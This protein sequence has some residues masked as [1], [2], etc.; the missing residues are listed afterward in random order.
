MDQPIVEHDVATWDQLAGAGCPVN[1]LAADI[2]AKVTVGMLLEAACW[3]SPGLVSPVDSGGHTDMTLPTF[4]SSSSVLAPGF[5]ILAALGGAGADQVPG[6]VMPQL[7]ATGKLFEQRMLQATGGV[8]THRG[9]LFLGGLLAAAAG[10]LSA[11]KG[12][13]S[14]RAGD[15]TAAAIGSTVA[16]FTSGIVRDELAQGYGSDR[17]LRLYQSS[18]LTGPRGEAEA[19]LPSVLRLGLPALR[20]A[21]DRGVSLNDALVHTLITLIAH[22][23]DTAL[24]GR[25]RANLL[26]ELVWPAAGAALQAGSVFTAKG[27]AAIFDLNQMFAEQRINPGGSADLLA[28][29]AAVYLLEKIKWP[30]GSE[31]AKSVFV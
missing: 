9:Y 4:L 29:T 8:N 12:I 26:A 22:V 5:A 25:H 23:P 6:A 28:L 13:S 30:A 24:A 27:R 11:G 2:A 17:A 14:L 1:L 20:L 10:Y 16:A 15:L 31:L 18:G 7:R 21:L 3:P 19:G